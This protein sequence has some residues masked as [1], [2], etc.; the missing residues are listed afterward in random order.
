M[1]EKEILSTSHLKPGHTL[2]PETVKL[3]VNFY[4]ISRIMPGKKD[5]MSVRLDG[6]RLHV[7]CSEQL[8]MY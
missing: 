1:K 2:T 6:K 5:L 3:V 8:L 7:Q 4:R